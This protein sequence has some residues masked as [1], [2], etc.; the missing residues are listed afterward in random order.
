M[1]KIIEET[2]KEMDGTTRRV[3]ERGVFVLSDA[4]L[5]A[6][7]LKNKDSDLSMEEAVDITRRLLARVGHQLD[8]LSRVSLGSFGYD[9]RHG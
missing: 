6:L 3:E 9:A 7:V 1:K 5:L 2:D 4:E 8:A